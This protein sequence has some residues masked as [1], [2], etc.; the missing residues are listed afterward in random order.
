M[1]YQELL[2]KIGD[3]AAI[4]SL[5]LPVSRDISYSHSIVLTES[6]SLIFPSEF[7][8]RIENFHLWDRQSAALLILKRKS[9]VPQNSHFQRLSASDG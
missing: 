2:E 5:S 8:R 3:L 7:F 9:A 1:I 4:S 6:S